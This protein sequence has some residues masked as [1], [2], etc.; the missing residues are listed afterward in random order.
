MN[1]YNRVTLAGNLTR[2][3]ELSYTPKG[4]PVAKF[5]MALNRKW[6]NG[7]GDL[8]EDC[9][10]VDV[11]AFGPKAETI[12]KHVAKGRPLLVEGRLQLDQ[13]DDKQSG[14]KR[15]KLYVVLEEFVFLNDGK[16]G[17]E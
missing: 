7:D 13:W 4:T 6:K 16:G 11:T 8:Q 5:G 14:E 15:S 9:T 12:A 2:V 3:P 1:G 10:F 17:A